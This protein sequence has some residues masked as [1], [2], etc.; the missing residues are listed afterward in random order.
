MREVLPAVAAA[1]SSSYIALTR[2]STAEPL[3]NWNYRVH[4]YPATYTVGPDLVLHY[5]RKPINATHHDSQ[6]VSLSGTLDFSIDVHLLRMDPGKS[7]PIKW[8]YVLPKDIN[9]KLDS[10]E[11]HFFWEFAGWSPCSATCGAGSR[12]NTAN[13]VSAATGT[14]AEDASKCSQFEEQPLP[15]RESCLSQPCPP[16]WWTGPRQ[17]C[18][19]NTCS[20]TREG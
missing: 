9:H 5:K 20:R 16:E 19:P 12:I 4:R 15:L 17:A 10:V 8:T 13:C 6:S 7:F 11:D 1:T 3:L 2:S 18:N 14:E